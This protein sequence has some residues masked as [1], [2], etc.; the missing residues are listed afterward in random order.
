MKKKII[1]DFFSSDKKFEDLKIGTKFGFERKIN[2][3]DIKKYANLVKDKNPL[4]LKQKKSDRIKK[5][6]IISHGMFV[7]SLTSTLL[8]T[9]CPIKNNILL[10]LKLNFKKPVL[11]N[12]KIKLQGR[13]VAKSDVLKILTIKISVYKMNVL[14][15]DGEA[16]LKVIQ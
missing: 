10:S 13:I 11:P 14:L 9:Y 4:H 12:Y 16:K 1:K 3:D 7:G 5:R 15:V 2:F 8:G 6:P